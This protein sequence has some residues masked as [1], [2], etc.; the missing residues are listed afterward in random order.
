MSHR[1]LLILS[2]EQIAFNF[3]LHAHSLHCQKYSQRCPLDRHVPPQVK[4]DGRRPRKMALAASAQR[5]EQ[6]ALR[7][8]RG[9][10]DATSPGIKWIHCTK[11]FC[12]NRKRD[13]SASGSFRHYPSLPLPLQVPPRPC[14][15]DSHGWMVGVPSFHLHCCS[16]S[17]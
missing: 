11:N 1:S 16:F 12:C 8:S 2:F 4:R 5:A 3:H 6:G 10:S 15:V 7:D 9:W 14:H 13:S 17:V